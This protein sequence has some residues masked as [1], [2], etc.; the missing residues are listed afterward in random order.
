MTL[1]SEIAALHRIAAAHRIG[2]SAYL[3]AWGNSDPS[4]SIASP[5]YYFEIYPAEQVGRPAGALELCIDFY[6]QARTAAP[7]APDW[8]VDAWEAGKVFF[9]APARRDGMRAL[10]SI[11]RALLRGRSVRLADGTEVHPHGSRA[12]GA[13]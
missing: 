10:S 2:Q 13:A 7:N 1:A 8:D 4:A 3:F 11:G 6:S 12:Q 9:T 5:S